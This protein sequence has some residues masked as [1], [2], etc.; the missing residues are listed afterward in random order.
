M[1]QRLAI[2]SAGI[3]AEC[4]LAAYA[5]LA[6]NFLPDG[7]LRS[8]VFVWATT[9]WVLTVLINMSP[10]MRF[11]G[12]YLFSDLIDVPNLAGSFFRTGASLVA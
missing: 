12:Y 8:V 1:V 3:A 9:T 7:I 2:G 4:C 6:W 10:F 11:D 5:I